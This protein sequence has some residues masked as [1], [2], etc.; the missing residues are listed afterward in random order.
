MS[1]KIILS[2]EQILMLF[3]IQGEN[4][5]TNPGVNPKATTYH[6]LPV[7]HHIGFKTRGIHNFNLANYFY[8]NSKPSF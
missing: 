4:K 7:I 8:F 5:K 3:H 2:T 1:M 6:L